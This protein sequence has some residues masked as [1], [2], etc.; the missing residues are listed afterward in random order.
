MA[1]L[2]ISSP[3]V[4]YYRKIEAFFK[5]DSDV[6]VVYDNDT[7]SLKLYVDNV[8]KASVLSNI[9]PVKKR[10]GKIDLKIAVIPANINEFLNEEDCNTLDAFKNNEAVSFIRRINGIFAD[11]LVYIV[12]KKEVVQY[13]TDDLSDYYGIHSTLY[14]DLARDIFTDIPGIYFS[15]DANEPK[16]LS[17]PL[18]EWP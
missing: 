4:V 14:E 1:N 12:F 11:E 6:H 18:G 15:T 5:Y 10:F 3:W 8:K 2:G 13:F 7:R 16:K 9:L 17:K